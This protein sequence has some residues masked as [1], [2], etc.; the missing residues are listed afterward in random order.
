MLLVSHGGVLKLPHL[1]AVRLLHAACQQ[2]TFD[3]ERLAQDLEWR[4][5]GRYGC[6]C[7][8]T[9]VCRKEPAAPTPKTGAGGRGAGTGHAGIPDSAQL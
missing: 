4:A 7:A 2:C 6:A 8:P 9:C 3:G 1:G 5:E